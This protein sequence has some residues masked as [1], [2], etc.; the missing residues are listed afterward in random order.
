MKIFGQ[1]VLVKQI[2]TRKKSKLVGLGGVKN[3]DLFD[4]TQK[5][6]MIS[7]DYTKGDIAIGD[8]PIFARY[9]DLGNTKIITKQEDYMET[10]IIVHVDDI[11]GI[12]DE[13]AV[14]TT[15]LA[16]TSEEEES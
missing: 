9:A 1:R 10:D 11:I 12:D 8:V 14:G 16:K 13:D 5:V 2:M 15:T 3:P 6:T 7:P 4:V